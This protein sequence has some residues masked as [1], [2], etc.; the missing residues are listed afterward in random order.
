VVT[1]TNHSMNASS[2][3]LGVL[4]WWYPTLMGKLKQSK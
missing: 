1:H 2:Q 3:Y 4:M